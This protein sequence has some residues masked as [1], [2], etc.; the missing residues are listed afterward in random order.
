MVGTPAGRSTSVTSRSA[1]EGAGRPSADRSRLVPRRAGSRE[2]REATPPKRGRSLYSPDY[3][4]N[5]N[6]T[7]VAFGSFRLRNTMHALTAARF[8]GFTPCPS[9]LAI[10]NLQ[11][12]GRSGRALVDGMPGGQASQP[13]AGP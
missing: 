6:A 8:W 3:Q 7:S 11:P 5:D 12:T 13:R 1:P 10:G 9:W 2:G 4:S